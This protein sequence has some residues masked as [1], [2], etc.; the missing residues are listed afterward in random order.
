MLGV[1]IPT[2]NHMVSEHLAAANE[3]R[4]A[5]F[6]VRHV[7]ALNPIAWRA[8]PPQNLILLGREGM[9]VKNDGSSDNDL[10]ARTACKLRRVADD[11]E[12]GKVADPVEW[13]I[14]MADIA[15]DRMDGHCKD[16][17]ERFLG[18]SLAVYALLFDEAVP[19]QRLYEI[20]DRNKRANKD[21]PFHERT[22]FARVNKRYGIESRCLYVGK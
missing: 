7:G 22:A 20:V 15:T 18:S 12:Q 17:A 10:I 4:L 21:K 16:I 13:V 11:L 8:S 14:S 5:A 2:G 3:Q 1:G 19:L 6:T 9:A